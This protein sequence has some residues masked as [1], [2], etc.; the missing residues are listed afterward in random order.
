M[1]R[2]ILLTFAVFFIPS[3]QSQWVQIST[4]ASSELYDVKFFNENT[5]IVAGQGGIWLST[6]SGVNW[7]QTLSGINSNAISFIDA[8]NGFV[9]CDSGKI[10]KSNNG[11]IN[12]SLSNSGVTQNLTGISF[13]NTNTGWAVGNGGIILKTTT[14]GSSWQIQTAQFPLNYNGVFMI[15]ATSGYIYGAS[16]EEAWVYTGNS[17]ANWSYTLNAPGN[18]IEGGSNI[19]TLLSNVI[20]VGSNGRI[21][22]STNNGLSWISITSGISAKL[23]CIQFTDISNVFIAGDFGTILKST[24]SGVNWSLQTTGTSQHLKSVYCI[25]SSTGWAVGENGAVLRSGIPVGINNTNNNIPAKIQLYQNFPNPFNPET[26]INYSIPATINVDL[27]IY[28]ILGQKIANLVNGIH[29]PGTFS[30]VWKPN[31]PVSGIYICKLKTSEATL[32][33][34]MLL[35]K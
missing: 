2:I 22:K 28:N 35:I 8:V 19:P 27:S 7:L 14:A 17:G 18:T 24:N 32:F 31:I 11:G 20:S 3:A 5:G 25:N 4:I 23:N 15:N 33:I 12:W 30:A 1:K 6:N 16:S 10:F 29:Q 13:V 26:K 34:R 21:R 9:A